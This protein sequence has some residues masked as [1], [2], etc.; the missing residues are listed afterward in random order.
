MVL[1]TLVLL[2]ALPQAA[3]TH[4]TPAD[5]PAAKVETAKNVTAPAARLP[6]GPA[7]KIATDADTNAKLNDAMNSDAAPITSIQPG[8]LAAPVKP[9]YTREY[10]NRR[11]KKIWYGLMAVSHGAAAFDA[12]ST[13]RAV[14]GGYGTEA[15][16]FL[17]GA[18]HSNMIYAATQ[19]SP[20]VM[21]F[22]GRKM[23]TSRHPWLRKMWWLPQTAGAGFSI[24]AGVHNTLLVP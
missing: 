5:S 18:S 16:P 4:D 2:C 13:R 6:E 24:S 1:A 20:A 15:N 23:M 8:S 17:R 14:A 3:I 11:Q 10:E 22:L 21:D 19:V 12:W 7:P 9:A